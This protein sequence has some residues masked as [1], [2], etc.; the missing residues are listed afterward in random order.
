MKS[1][2]YAP[3]TRF[4]VLALGWLFA[5]VVRATP[6][7]LAT[8]VR[9]GTAQYLNPDLRLTPNFDTNPGGAVS[10]AGAAWT[11]TTY[12]VVDPFAVSFSFRMSDPTGQMDPSNDQVGGDGIA[13][14]IQ[15]SAAGTGALGVG[16]GG[17]GFLGITNSVA[18]MFDT[19]QNN[20]AYGDPSGNYVAVNTRGPLSINVPHHFC[21]GN[22]LTTDISLPLDLPDEDCNTDPSLGMAT[23]PGFLLNDGLVHNVF[24]NYNPGQLNVFLDGAAILS[25]ALDLGQ[26]LNLQNGT[27]AYLGFTAG[28]RFSYQNQDIVGLTYAVPE[29]ST[30]LLILGGLAGLAM[31][32]RKRNRGASRT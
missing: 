20:Y 13:F 28:T 26:T 11:P 30:G 21:T 16:A 10:P 3:S 9:V 14:L 6:I 27:N 19:Y 7:D 8:L 23:V 22:E 24:L 31:F 25:V 15:N 17:L 12:N 29:P 1:T 2:T 32:Q 18:I 5:S 4:A